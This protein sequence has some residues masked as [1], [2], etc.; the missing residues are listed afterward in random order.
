MSLGKSDGN[1]YPWVTHM[2]S[3]LGGECPHR[4]SYCYVGKLWF[5][6]PAK[7][8]GPP[9]LIEKE[10]EVRYGKGRTI[11]LEHCN[12][13]FAEGIES[14]WI[15]AIL[16]HAREYPENMYVIQ[17]KNP[18]RVADWLGA[19]PQSF[20]LGTTIE[21][22]RSTESLTEAPSTA[23][24]ALSMTRFRA[25]GF[26]MFVTIEPILDFDPEILAGWIRDIKPEFINIGADSKSCGLPEPSAEKVRRFLEL[27]AGIEIR[28][29]TNLQRIKDGAE[30]GRHFALAGRSSA[31]RG[32]GKAA[33]DRP[34]DRI[35]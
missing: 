23:D 22:N 33:T 13:M 25:M 2:H 30:F 26:K 12:D 14:A 24:R 20:I 21:T 3:H 16:S 28:E 35:L 8:T 34:A 29:K 15:S 32:K 5:G 1:M 18:G 27:M 11:F 17:T 9:R 10:L 6:R 7:Y 31:K 19:L 4:C